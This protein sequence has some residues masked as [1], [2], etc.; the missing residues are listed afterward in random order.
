MNFDKIY[1]I[2]EIRLPIKNMYDE[3]Q[4]RKIMYI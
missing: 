4:Y 2:L 1:V 3:I